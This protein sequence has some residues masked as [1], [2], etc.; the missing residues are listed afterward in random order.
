M[1]TIIYPNRLRVVL[2]DKQITN[3]WL[4]RKLSV[5]DM[6]VSRWTTNKIQ[7]SVSQLIEIAK[8]LSVR[9]D[10]LVEPYSK[11]GNQ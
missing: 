6:T 7:P 1:K 2:A 5:T 3:R 9:L 10:D 11:E 8:M 4:A